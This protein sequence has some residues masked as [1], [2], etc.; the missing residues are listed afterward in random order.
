MHNRL[1][2]LCSFKAWA[3][4]LLMP[5]LPSPFYIF[6]SSLPSG[7][8]FM[9]PLFSSFLLD[10]VSFQFPALGFCHMFRK[11]WLGLLLKM[12]NQFGDLLRNTQSRT[13]S[14]HRTSQA[15][16]FGANVLFLWSNP[17]NSST[18][19]AKGCYSLEWSMLWLLLRASPDSWH[20][21]DAEDLGW[22]VDGEGGEAGSHLKISL[23]PVVLRGNH[24]SGH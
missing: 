10:W 15:L 24:N 7:H 14:L 3:S 2:T 9:L 4:D 18:R 20:P 8:F 5:P 19:Q 12:A 22:L 1:L 13:R 21:R 6:H 23:C 17:S 16:E 11:E